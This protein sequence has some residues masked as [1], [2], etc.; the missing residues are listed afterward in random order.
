MRL[1]V[2]DFDYFFP[3]VERASD[4]KF[5]HEWLLY[6]WNHCEAKFYIEKFLWTIR[7][8]AFV[9][10][11]VE[12]PKTSG[13]EQTF[14]QRFKISPKAKLFYADSNVYAA[15]FC[16]RRKV[17][18][19]YLFDAHHDCGYHEK[20]I[21]RVLDSDRIDCGDWMLAYALRD[22]K[23][24]VR[25]PKW[26]AYAMQLEPEPE[27]EVD[28]RVDDEQPLRMRFDR[29]FVCRSGAWVA[30]WLDEAFFKFIE[31]APVSER[32]LLDDM[33]SRDWTDEDVERLRALQLVNNTEQITTG[34]T[35]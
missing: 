7:A 2:V 33:T 26:R 11:G 18:E 8:E 32:V 29:V 25:Y 13:L 6:D 17:K 19:L 15:D 14:W 28:R 35:A 16:V 34:E 9:R 3:V 30:P 23:L 4:S 10:R 5:P 27:C 21:D 12:L 24:H 1:L 31:A 22:A 20:S